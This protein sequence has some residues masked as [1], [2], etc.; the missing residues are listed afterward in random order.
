MIETSKDNG[1]A[2]N[3]ITVV[4]IF[5][6]NRNKTITTKKLPSNKLFLTLLIELSIK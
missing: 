1:K 4:R 5:I 2:T 3:E 6:K